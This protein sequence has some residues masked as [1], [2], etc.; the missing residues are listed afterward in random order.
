VESQTED[1]TCPHAL[2]EALHLLDVV[3]ADRPMPGHLRDALG[4]V[5]DEEIRLQAVA[6]G[7]AHE[8]NDRA[9]ARKAEHRI[10]QTYLSRRR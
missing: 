5:L 9:A 4:R 6:L 2:R 10:A 8:F 1:P 7:E 3:Q